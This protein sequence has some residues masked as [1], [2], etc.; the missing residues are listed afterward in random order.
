MLPLILT[1]NKFTYYLRN[2]SPSKPFANKLLLQLKKMVSHESFS[3]IYRFCLIA[4]GLSVFG[5][6][7]AS[8]LPVKRLQCS[9]WGTVF[10]PV[11]VRE[12]EV[13]RWFSGYFRASIYSDM[14]KKFS[15]LA[16]QH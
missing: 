12:G 4:L 5:I 6:V 2:T 13:R 10:T 15:A 9:I 1:E 3:K 16:H 7:L 14:S 8:I 11:W